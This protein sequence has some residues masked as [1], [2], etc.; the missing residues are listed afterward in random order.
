MTVSFVD[1]TPVE[2]GEP[3]RPF[4]LEQLDRAMEL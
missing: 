1:P 2:L 4:D 3:A